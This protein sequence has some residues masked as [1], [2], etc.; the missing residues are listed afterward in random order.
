MTEIYYDISYFSRKVQ[1]LLYLLGTLLG[2]VHMC[3]FTY[4]NACASFKH[5]NM[6]SG[7]SALVK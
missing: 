7:S 1:V 6:A 2:S 3:I 5:N 4:T